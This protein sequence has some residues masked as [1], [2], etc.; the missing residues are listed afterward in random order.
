MSKITKA[1]ARFQQD[2]FPSKAKFIVQ[3]ATLKIAQGAKGKELARLKK[4]RESAKRVLVRLKTEV[5]AGRATP[6]K[7]TKSPKKKS[8]TK[9]STPESRR[10]SFETATGIGPGITD[11]L[12]GMGK[13]S[14]G[15][16]K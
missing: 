14:K 15:K 10:K 16:K 2:T 3:D 9:K 13:L 5:D 11:K 7:V 4:A 8:P 12:K 1:N 6:R